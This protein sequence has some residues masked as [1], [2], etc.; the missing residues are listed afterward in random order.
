MNAQ[1]VNL[2]SSMGFFAVIVSL[3]AM[4]GYG[5]NGTPAT[6][7]EAYGD[8]F[9]IGA[10]I[11]RTIATGTAVKADNVDR[12][13]DQVKA[14]T[15]LVLAHYNQIVNENDLKWVM[16]QPNPGPEGYDFP[17]ADAFVE[18]GL[19]ND[20]YLVGHTLVWHS[21]VPGWLFQADPFEA[22]D[23]VD[24]AA[25]QR[26]GGRRRRVTYSGPRATREQLLERM[27]DHIHTVVGRYK[28]KI[29]VWDVVNEALADGGSDVLRSTPWTQIIG[30]DFIAKAFE[31]AHEADPDAI[32][33]YN[34]YGLEN[35]G[36]RQKLFT[37]IRQLQAQNVPVHAIGTQT[38]INVSTTFETMDRTLAE[39]ASLGLPVHITELDVNAA[40]RG[41]QTTSADIT[42]SAERTQGGVVS[43]ADRRQ[44]EAY[45][46]LF[47]AIMKHKDSVK[48]VT[49]WGANDAV[50]WLARGTPLLFDGDNQPKPAFDAVI[51]VAVEASQQ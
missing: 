25:A 48:M 1:N 3:A 2:N 39:L 10:A 8:H 43:E 37:L 14:D 15:A 46:N 20:L 42:G 9:Y 45:A 34:D 31:Y 18:F 28:G 49:F 40:V 4:T 47:R 27:R 38:H 11:N 7:K 22:P 17:P 33:R 6:L 32:L 26:P 13:L 41:Q 30:P 50:S 16:I 24:E 29:K 5:S 12:T 35:P 19:K 36:K 21:Q 51:R 44:A 23:P